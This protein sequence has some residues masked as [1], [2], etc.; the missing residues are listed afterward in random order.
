L[1]PGKGEWSSMNSLER[2]TYVAQ[3]AALAA[4]AVTFVFSFLTW[5]EARLAGELSKSSQEQERAFFVA[6]NPPF[7]EL[8]GGH[9]FDSE[10]GP[11][12]FLYIRNVGDSAARSPCADIRRFHEERGEISLTT[13]C[14]PDDSYANATLPKNAGVTYHLPQRGYLPFRPERVIVLRPDQPPPAGSTCTGRP[15]DSLLVALRFKNVVGEQ[16]QIIR[17]VILC[18]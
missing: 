7:L 11:I 3:W 13:N 5:R 10:A 6:Q 4:L 1:I 9:V 14:T 17:Q 2:V 18:G 15:S 8:I 16:Q 12:L